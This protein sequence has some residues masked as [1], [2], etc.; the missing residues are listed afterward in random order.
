M[1]KTLMERA[2]TMLSGGNL[3]KELWVE[4]I[5]TVC[6]LINMNP[7]SFL[8]NN[9]PMEICIGNNPSLQHLCVFGHEAYAHLPKEKRLKLDK[10]YFKCIFFSYSIGVKMYKIWDPIAG[11]FFY[12][13]V[14]IFREGNSSPIVVKLEEGEKLMFQLPLKIEKVE[15]E[16]EKEVHDR[17]DEEKGS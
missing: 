1:N 16:N 7:T 10:K 12:S 8:V 9:T 15:L 4:S 11:F 5:S 3:E 13:R 17:L 14:V 2:R 6:L